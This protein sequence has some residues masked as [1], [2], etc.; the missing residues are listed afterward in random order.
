MTD[1][2]N[3]IHLVALHGAADGAAPSGM[4]HRAD[5]IKVVPGSNTTVDGQPLSEIWQELLVRNAAF[6]RTSLPLLAALTFP[7]VRSNEK[8]A[9]PYNPGFQ[10]ATEFGKPTKIRVSYIG[11]GFPI[12][13]YDLG[14]GYTQEFID[15]AR[16]SEILAIQS[17]VE[18][19]YNQLRHSTI[20]SALFNDTNTTDADGVN[21]KRLYNADGEVPPAWQRWTHDGTHT[22]YL[23]S[24]NT[25]FTYANI[26]T[27]AEHLI[28]HGFVA[29]GSRLLLFA[30]RDDLATLRGLSEFVPAE[31]AL[32]PQIISGPI[33][34]PTGGGF[35]S[36]Q[37]VGYVGQFTVL[38]SDDIPSGYLLAVATGGQ[39]SRR[40]PVG[41][42]QHENPSARGLRLVQGPRG[43][44]PLIDAVY[45]TYIGAGVGQRGA[46]VIMQETSGAYTVPT[47]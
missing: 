40:N 6:Q 3:L 29:T 21:V 45:D 1:K 25:A 4:M 5:A 11:R 19:A 43:E 18:L 31:T 42:R 28:H 34:G 12:A 7:V 8:L 30:H 37:P 27:M 47:F 46:A 26:D 32:S 44:Y 14:Y 24:G 13:H 35:G 9:V 22:H 17:E 2:L 10:Q 39:F 23:T 36:F 20:L 16:G 41:L 15:S 33:V 38:N